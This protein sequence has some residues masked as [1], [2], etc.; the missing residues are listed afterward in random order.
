[1]KT[2][3]SLIVGLELGHRN[4]LLEQTAIG[5]HCFGASHEWNRPCELCECPVRKVLETSRKVTVTHYYETQLGGRGKQR[6]VR[7]LA[8][9][10]RDS[11]GNITQVAE[12]I[13]DAD[14]IR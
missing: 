1:M 14:D 12:L 10:V 7:V 9:P 4:K 5:Q 3:K 6:L 11:Q 13:W 2:G 8:S